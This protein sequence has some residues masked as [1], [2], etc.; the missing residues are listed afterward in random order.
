MKDYST[1][2]H[3]ICRSPRHICWC[4]SMWG[5]LLQGATSAAEGL[6][7]AFS[8]SAHASAGHRGRQH[9][10]G[11]LPAAQA[12]GMLDACGAEVP[13]PSDL[14]AGAQDEVTLRSY[15]YLSTSL[16]PVSLTPLANS[17]QNRLGCRDTPEWA[18]GGVT[19]SSVWQ[20]RGKH[21]CPNDPC[22]NSQMMH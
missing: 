7:R 19:K 9:P 14:D 22:L 11:A 18:F 1:R 12:Q 15:C 13:A 10:P 8:S 17:L 20:D 5:C 16:A 2:R 4:V 6:G 21:V 3:A